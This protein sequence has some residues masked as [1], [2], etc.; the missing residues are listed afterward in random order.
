[1]SESTL[2]AWLEE[3]HVHTLYEKLGDARQIIGLC[4]NVLSAADS[5]YETD[6]ARGDVDPRESPPFRAG[7]TQRD[8]AV[9]LEVAESIM[10]V[11]SVANS[12]ERELGG[13]SKVSGT[14]LTWPET[15]EEEVRT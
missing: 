13:F 14:L 12:S 3:E 7:I 8:M 4:G 2:V 11:V 6:L 1:M 9:L 5:Y 15:G 10:K